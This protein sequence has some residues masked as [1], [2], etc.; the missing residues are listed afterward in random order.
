MLRASSDTVHDSATR[1]GLPP[2]VDA[3]GVVKICA[4]GIIVAMP[5]CTPG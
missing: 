4:P 5:D 2:V 3:H 1:H